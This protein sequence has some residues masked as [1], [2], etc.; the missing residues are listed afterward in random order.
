MK[1]NVFCLLLTT[2]LAMIAA[3]L[4]AEPTAK[5]THKRT[6]T[7]TQKSGGQN[8]APSAFTESANGWVYVNSEWVHPEGYKLVN[9][10]VLRTT[11]KTGKAAPM[12]PG[13]LALQ[14]PQKLTP[15]N[16]SAPTN[17]AADNAKTA[18]EKAAEIRRRNLTPT[19]APQTGS[20][21]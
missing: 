11:A 5:T 21:L 16:N 19:A 10:K 8:T 13:K 2:S 3:T 6:T 14:N 12:P 18:A 15:K 9:G 1:R 17:S 7:K 4:N 20:H